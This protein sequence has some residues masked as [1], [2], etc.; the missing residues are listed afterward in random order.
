VRLNR[1]LSVGAAAVVLAVSGVAPASAGTRD[2]VRPVPPP[3]SK[4]TAQL[5][6]P[7]GHAIAP[8]PAPTGLR[9]R[10]LAAAPTSVCAQVHLQDRGWQQGRCVGANEAVIVGAAG[11]G[12]A[13]EALSLWVYGVNFCAMGHVQDIGWQEWACAAGSDSV[14]VGTTGQGRRMES[15]AY[16]VQTGTICGNA[17]VQDIGWQGW[18]CGVDG[19]YNA[20]GTTGQNRRIEA[21][22]FIVW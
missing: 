19:D 8:P 5:G 10:N 22:S 14:T 20:A 12:S 16:G 11:E 18:Y 15:V 3:L 4:A 6:L 17:Y 7:A 13:I 9:A 1:I 21:L 2:D